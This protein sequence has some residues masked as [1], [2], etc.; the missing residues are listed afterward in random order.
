MYVQTCSPFSLNVN[1][2]D[3]NYFLKLCTSVFVPGGVENPPPHPSEI[4]M[5]PLA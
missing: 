3:Y 2:T 5:N 1:R 4:V